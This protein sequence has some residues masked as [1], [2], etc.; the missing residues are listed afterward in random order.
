ML[1]SRT[2]PHR[3]RLNVP[4]L[5]KTAGV[6][7]VSGSI[8][9]RPSPP[10]GPKT[11]PPRRRR[12]TRGRLRLR[13]GAGVRPEGTYASAAAQSFDPRARTHPPASQS[14]DPTARTYPPRRSRS[15][16]RRVR[17]RRSAVVSVAFAWLRIVTTAARVSDDAGR[18]VGGSA[19]TPV[20]IGTV[21]PC[22]SKSKAAL[23]KG[24]QGFSISGARQ[25]E[26]GDHGAQRA[27]AAP[28][29][30]SACPAPDGAS[31]PRFIGVSSSSIINIK[32]P[33]GASA[34]AFRLWS[35]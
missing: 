1:P 22:S 28:A 3:R 35:L 8:G 18:G 13:R 33:P 26:K 34:R 15:T 10:A 2:T 23:S 5:A 19:P 16:R 4:N 17:I 9:P 29:G 6:T 30:S 25:I 11:Y 31:H 20:I 14:F 7:S 32:T 21:I 24:V 27:T 12:S